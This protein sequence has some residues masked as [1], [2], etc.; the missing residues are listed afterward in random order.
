M[1]AFNDFVGLTE[2]DIRDMAYGFS[3]RIIAPGRINYGMRR[4]EYTL[5]IIN[6]AQDEIRCSR[7][8]SLID[9]ADAEEYKA[10]LGKALDRATLRKF[11]ADQTDTIIKEGDLEKFKDNRR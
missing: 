10:L 5:G 4:V 7:T 1:K 6:W 11:E 2:S 8:T 9:I 3:K